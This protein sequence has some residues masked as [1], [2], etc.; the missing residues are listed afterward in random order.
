[1]RTESEPQAGKRQTQAIQWSR[2]V[3]A[4]LSG[5]VAESR[6][7]PEQEVDVGQERKQEGIGEGSDEQEFEAGLP[8]E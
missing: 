8:D 3:T 4:P 7:Q 6:E 1:M 5:S 2:D